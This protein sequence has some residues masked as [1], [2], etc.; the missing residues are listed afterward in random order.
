MSNPS[1]NI[2]YNSQEMD[3]FDDVF[4]VY[5]NEMVVF[6]PVSNCLKRVTSD[7]IGRFSTNDID[8]SSPTVFYEGQD[9]SDGVWI[10]TKTEKNI[11]VTSIR[12]ATQLNNNSITN[13]S[14]AWTNR[15]TLTYDIYSVAF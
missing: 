13:Y 1:G 11:N 10:L 3:S 14:D 4:K 7:A 12:Y 9:D 5:V 2:K 6:D 8:K 15:A